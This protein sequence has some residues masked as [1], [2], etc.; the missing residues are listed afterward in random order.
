[1]ARLRKQRSLP[2]PPQIAN[3][4]RGRYPELAHGLVKARKERCLTWTADAATRWDSYYAT[5]EK[6]PSEG[7]VALLTAR[8]PAQLVRGEQV[9]ALAESAD[10]LGV[11]HFEAA[12]A[13]VEY[14]ER[15]AR[16]IFGDSTGNRHADALLLR[17]LRQGDMPRLDA[18]RFLGLRL[19]SDLDEIEDLL[20]SLGLIRVLETV[21]AGGGRPRRVY[22]AMS[23]NWGDQVRADQRGCRTLAATRC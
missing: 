5:F 19:A 15:S 10:A 11:E 6:R 18:Q 7:T 14:A 13:V 2:R 20:V 3:L 23:A 4:V 8:Q 17:A 12:K 16:Y 1:M 22:R 21:P 9:Y